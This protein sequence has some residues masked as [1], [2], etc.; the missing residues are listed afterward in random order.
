M[1]IIKLSVQNFRGILHLDWWTDQQPICCLIGPGDSLKSTILDAVEA[2][3]SSRWFSFGEADFTQCDTT[4]D[5][6]IEVTV[7]ELSKQLLSDEK[8]GLYIRGLSPEGKLRDEPEDGDEAVLT[9]RLSVDATME[10]QW[11]AIN[12]R[13]QYPRTMSNRDRAL[14]RVVRLTGDDAR[15]LTWGQGSILAKLTESGDEA[16][17]QLAEAYRAA[18]ASAQLDKIKSLVEVATEAQKRAVEVGAQ[19]SD[20][21]TPGLELGRGGFSAGSIALH[22]GKV[23]LRLAGTGTRRLATLAIQR[24]AIDEGAI[25]L[26]DEIEQ[27]LEPHRILG[28]ISHLKR[29]QSEAVGTGRPTGQILMTTHS[30]IAL[31]EVDPKALFVCR[32]AAAGHLNVLHPSDQVAL[33]RVL[34]HSP[35]ALFA[36]RILVCEGDTELGLALG[37]RDLYPARRDDTSI[38]QRGVAIIDGGGSAA[39]HVAAALGG[40]GFAV[41]LYRDSD[42]RL[43]A[44]QQKELDALLVTTITYMSNIAV[45][46]AIFMAISDDA[47]IDILLIVAEEFKGSAAVVDQINKA[48][49][50]VGSDGVSD[51]TFADWEFDPPLT[52]AEVIGRLGLLA[53]KNGWFKNRYISRGLAPTVDKAVQQDPKTEMAAALRTIEAW[54]YA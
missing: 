37:L 41:A 11:E 2:A 53:K 31:S 44:A 19:I 40:L 15:H 1:K 49:P 51:V 5:L 12:D 16:A 21:Y 13:A 39:P 6:K 38:E 8:F 35:R 45:D 33:K 14:F 10:P 54:L 47:L 7:G 30:D 46:Q 42:V 27:G 34:K 36:R 24:A 4:K 29:S 43:P 32:R 9:I 48:F 17:Q 22:D 26:V 23:P 25:V 50:E 52:R 28:A 3:L 20:R 18:K